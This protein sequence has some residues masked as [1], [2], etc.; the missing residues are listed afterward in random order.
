MAFISEIHY[1]D[2]VR[3]STGVNE[4]VEVALTADEF[5]RVS[6][7]DIASY[8]SDGTAI[9]TTN[10]STLTPTL[11]PSSGLYVF[12]FEAEF[13]EGDNAASQIAEAVALTDSAAVPIVLDFYDI[14]GGTQNITAL[15]G[16]ANGATS[17]NI[18]GNAPGAQSIQFD[19]QG[20]RT[21]GNLSR[22][23]AVCYCAKTEL[24][25]PEGPRAVGSL[26][27]GTPVLTIDHGFQ[28][29]RLVSR[30]YHTWPA[31]QSDAADK[32]ILIPMN[33]FGTGLPRADLV[34]PPQHRI[35]LP[36]GP[37]KAAPLAPAKGLIGWRGIRRMRGAREV[38]YVH[39]ILD[40]HEVL[41]ANALPCESFF[42]GAVGV[43]ILR[44]VTGCNLPKGRPRPD[45]PARAF[46]TVGETR[47]QRDELVKHWPSHLWEPEEKP[48]RRSGLDPLDPCLSG[49]RTPQFAEMQSAG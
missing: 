26:T 34:V 6:D 10:L 33:S 17:E 2:S 44:D 7:F 8:N 43:S 27:P 1:A 28:P 42:A 35:L 20:N 5:A 46:W 48:A 32:P 24:L 47:R 23:S 39:V 16:P 36:D 22:G 31:G 13:S 41:W 40:R 4:F 38:N 9:A 19:N 3:S 15:D 18:S 12:V 25:T 29:V 11:D 30:S 49:C 14:G 21:D 45:Q 37:P